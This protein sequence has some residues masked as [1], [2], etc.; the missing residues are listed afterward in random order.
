MGKNLFIYN[1]KGK[2]PAACLLTAATVLCSLIFL[3][4]LPEKTRSSVELWAREGNRVFYVKNRLDSLG[5]IKDLS[6]IVFILGDST[7]QGFEEELP[8]YNKAARF[9]CLNRPAFTMA[10]YFC[11]VNAI[12]P[13]KPMAI[14]VC[15]N[16]ATFSPT[17]E[18]NAAYR[19]PEMTA[20]CAPESLERYGDALNRFYGL[21]IKEIRS[22]GQTK[23]GS[24][25][26]DTIMGLRNIIRSWIK[27]NIEAGILGRRTKDDVS[28][29]K[30]QEQL[31]LNTYHI[32]RG[33][34]PLTHPYF[35]FARAI[36][37]L[38]EKENVKVIFYITPVDT[39]FMRKTGIFGQIEPSIIYIKNN[40]G[41]SL[42]GS[43]ARLYDF[44]DSLSGSDIVDTPGHLKKQGREKIYAFLSESLG[45]L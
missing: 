45:K 15:I 9:I 3:T 38:C 42:S 27:D 22:Y 4:A 32:D 18:N 36:S 5:G 25:F 29:S 34:L 44:H 40:F 35:V 37:E 24:A 41:K 33:S 11:I 31:F 39:E 16:L 23:K 13:L 8:V 26:Y 17:Y 14:I 43:G 20:L 7:T 10:D 12:A 1:F 30:K 19:F 28:N 2:Y 21:S 6:G